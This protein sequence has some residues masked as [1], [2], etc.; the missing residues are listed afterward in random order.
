[1]DTGADIRAERLR[2]TLALLNGYPYIEPRE[3]APPL[4]AAEVILERT[5]MSATPSS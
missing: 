5:L 1:M 4:S 2:V 3:C